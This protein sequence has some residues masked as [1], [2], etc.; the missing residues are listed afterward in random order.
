[1]PDFRTPDGDMQSYYEYNGK[2][3]DEFKFEDIEHLLACIPGEND[4]FNWHWIVRLKNGK[5]GYVT[6]WCD[7]TGWDCQSGGSVHIANSARDA[8][9]LA[10]DGY[11]DQG[12][13]EQLMAQLIGVQNYGLRVFPREQ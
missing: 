11:E 1:M 4:G 5:Y 9:L 8:A 13:M 6:A 10:K 7:Y 2:D 3:F 12:I